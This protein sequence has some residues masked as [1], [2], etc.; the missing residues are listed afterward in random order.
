M[1]KFQVAH[2]KEQ[3]VDLI[4]VFVN[5]SFGRKS[6]Q[7]QWDIRDALQMCANAAGLSG[8]VVPVWKTGFIAPP[9]W[10]PFFK[11]PNIYATLVA[12]INQELT[13]G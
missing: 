9:N 12:N 6:Q 3:G 10:H 1:Q 2:F 8:T 5:D 7:E 13:C 11:S 4:V